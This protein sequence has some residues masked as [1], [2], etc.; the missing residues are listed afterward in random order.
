MNS[1]TNSHNLDF[2]IIS[3]SILSSGAYVSTVLELTSI[4]SICFLLSIVLVIVFFVVISGIR[5]ISIQ[6]LVTI[7]LIFLATLFTDVQL[8]FD[9]FKYAIIT[10]CILLIF[11]NINKLT[12]TVYSQR[13]IQVFTLVSIIFTNLMYYV[14]GLRYK[15]YG[16]TQC[17]YLNF[18]N[19]NTA[20]IWLTLFFTL[21]FACALMINN[22]KWKLLHFAASFSLL[23]I[24][25]ATESRNCILSCVLLVAM[26]LILL[27]LKIT[28]VPRWI[29]LIF[30]LL[31][32]IFFFLYLYVIIP[33]E[34]RI[35]NLE[36][37]SY[38]P[39]SSGKTIA[40]RNIIWKSILSDIPRCF[41]LGDYGQYNMKNLHNSI[42]TLFSSYG[43]F[44]TFLFFKQIYKSLINLN[45]LSQCC[46][47]AILFTGC[48]E[49]SIFMGIS[50]AYLL[51]VLICAVSSVNQ[52]G[53]EQ[54]NENR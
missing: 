8:S 25:Y 17:V 22:W 42:M 49:A 39:H 32:V 30:V 24:I 26:H 20:G 4:T 41:V 51:L 40:T 7:L 15:Y 38:L 28:K 34:T 23:P 52:R 33:Y 3:S 37:L 1:I 29:C 31:P 19:P 47:I 13:I 10:I 54:M 12:A 16:T 48:F 9:Y 6:L 2:F 35:T 46:V 43:F 18:E 5:K 36:I 45:C 11:V 50:G 21:G 53:E 44:I 27:L 14:G